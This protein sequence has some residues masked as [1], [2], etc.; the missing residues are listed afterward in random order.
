[1]SSEHHFV[2]ADENAPPKLNA[3]AAALKKGGVVAQVDAG[4][5]QSEIV[6]DPGKAEIG[7]LYCDHDGRTSEVHDLTLLVA[8]KADPK[9]VAVVVGIV[10][11]AGFVLAET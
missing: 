9:R 11:A 8:K 4:A 1:M 2:P 6:L 10:T 7:A 3:L 5:D